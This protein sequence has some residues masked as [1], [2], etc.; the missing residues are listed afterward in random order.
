MKRSHFQKI[1]ERLSV[2]AVYRCEIARRFTEARRY[3]AEMK[4]NNRKERRC[5]MRILWLSRHDMTKTQ[6]RTLRSSIQG[7][8]TAEIICRTVEWATTEDE[9]ADNEANALAWLRLAGEAE[10]VAGVFPVFAITG[11]LTARG[12][13]DDGEAEWVAKWTNPTVITP[14]SRVIQTIRNGEIAKQFKFLRW[15]HI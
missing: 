4:E 9:R 11:L 2:F 10:V 6:E 12:L 8:E 13:A 3:L 14:V 7:G 5:R 15:Q 1:L